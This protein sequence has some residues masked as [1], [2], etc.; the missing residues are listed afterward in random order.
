MQRMVA[1]SSPDPG[2]DTRPRPPLGLIEY[3]D[4]SRSR[5][6]PAA[7]RRAFE[8]ALLADRLGYRRVWLPEH[9]STGSPSTNPLPLVAV[10]GSHTTRIR[11]GTA[12]TLVRIR[13]PYL[14]AEDIVTAGA[15]C[16]DR[17]DVGFGRGDVGGPAAESLRPLRKDDE[18]TDRAIT[19][20][21]S[22]LENG[23]DW[24]D[25]LGAPCQRWL[26]GAGTRSAALAARAGDNY[27]HALFLNPDLDACLR[28][29]AAYRDAHPTGTSAVAIAFVANP[30]AATARADSVQHRGIHI[31]CAGTAEQCAVTVTT[32]LELTGVD[33]V[34]IAELSS[35]PGDHHR[36]L[37]AVFDHV[38]RSGAGLERAVC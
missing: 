8:G 25:P 7:A 22:I 2:I 5:P 30:D 20:I 33:E 21:S 17:L 23:C 32:L 14:T 28:P 12:V 10:L 4:P 24:I 37:R 13:D 29:L 38:A 35:D 16:G 1:P 11:V 9:H 31:A 3:L 19:L 34:V 36:A 6:A 26:H 18:D 27:C 15:F